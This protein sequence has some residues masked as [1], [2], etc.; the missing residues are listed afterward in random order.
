MTQDIKD[1]DWEGIKKELEMAEAYTDECGNL[2]KAIYLGSFLSLSPSGKYYTPWANSNVTQE[3]AE[4]DEKWCEELEEE[5]G[6]H[7]LFVTSGEGDPTDIVIGKV[8][9]EEEE[10]RACLV[11]LRPSKK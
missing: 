4:E 9:E 6:K 10:G 3:E 8:V 11:P 1:I 2:V 5:A 7:G